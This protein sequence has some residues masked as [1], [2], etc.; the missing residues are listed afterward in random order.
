MS[1]SYQ[2]LQSFQPDLATLAEQAEQLL[3]TNPRSLLINGRLFAEQLATLVAR[4]EGIEPVY[5]I[6]QIERIQ[7]LER[8]GIINSDIR[9]SLEWLRMNGNSA[10][11]EAKEI[12]IDIAL[13]AHRQ[14]FELSAWFAETYGPHSLEIP[15]YEIPVKPA[16][17]VDTKNDSSTSEELNETLQKL[18]EDQLSGKLLTSID[19]KFREIQGMLDRFAGNIEEWAQKEKKS[20]VE[21]DK[22]TTIQEAAIEESAAGAEARG[23]NSQME[24]ADYLQTLSLQ[25]LDKRANGGALWIIGGWELKDKLFALKPFGFYFRFARN[26]SQSTKRKPAWF[27]MGKDP[28]VKRWVRI[29]SLVTPQS[30]LKNINQTSEGRNGKTV[31]WYKNGILQGQFPSI[32]AAATFI[33][34]EMNLKHMPF[35]PIMKSIHQNID[36][37]DLSFSF[38]EVKG[39]IEHIEEET[40]ARSRHAIS[41]SLDSDR[42][43]YD[44]LE[45]PYSVNE[46]AQQADFSRNGVV[47]P[48]AIRFKQLEDYR[49]S[50]L[51]EISE[52]LGV[53]CFQDWTEERLKEL[54]RKEP[55]LLHDVLVQLWFYGFEF[56]GEL[57]RFIKLDRTSD[58]GAIDNLKSG[59][60]L[61]NIFPLDISRSLERFGVRS[62]DQ[63][64]GIPLSSL[65]WLLRGRYDD[66]IQALEPYTLSE[67]GETVLEK[68]R[69]EQPLVLHFQGRALEIP[70]S[71][72]DT[73]I[74]SMPIYGCSALLS[75]LN[76]HCQ[77][78]LVRELPSDLSELIPLIP[79]VG[80]GSVNKMFTQ[81]SDYIN[82]IVH[83]DTKSDFN[84][85]AALIEKD[86]NKRA[87]ESG[88]II[89]QDVVIELDPE[90]CAMRLGI[91]HFPMVTKLMRGIAAQGWAQVG[92][93][94][95]RLDKLLV[96]DGVGRMAISKFI[97]QLKKRL[98]VFRLE[99]QQESEWITMPV[100]QRISLSIDNVVAAWSDKITEHNIANNRNLQMLHMRWTERREGRKATLESLGQHFGL[101]RERV[102]QII[103]KQLR[104]FHP[105]VVSFDNLLKSTCRQNGNYYYYYLDIHEKF[106]Y[107]LIEQVVEESEGL[108][109]LENYGWWTTKTE[110]EVEA[111]QEKVRL[112]IREQLRGNLV[113]ND[114]LEE[115]I[116]EQKFELPVKLA[117]QM[118]KEHLKAT[119]D[120]KYLLAASTKA[121]IVEMV[122]RQYPNGVEVYKR[123]SELKD[124]ANRIV[125]D[126]FVNER[127]FTSVCTRDE[128]SDAAYLW[129]RGTYIHSSFVNVKPEL[130]REVSELALQM[131]EKRSPI[132]VGRLFQMF[133]DRLVDANVPN[134]YALYSMLRKYGSDG[135]APNKF[136][137]IWHKDDAFQLSNAELIKAFMRERQEPQTLEALR[138]E[139]IRKRGWKKF[140]LE[141]SMST[142]SDFISVDLGVVGLREF[143]PYVE[144]DFA[145]ITRELKVLLSETG[146]IHVNRLFES[147]KPQCDYMGIRSSYLLYD[148]LQGLNL[149]DCK[150]VRYPLVASEDHPLEELSLQSI[151]E[152]YIAD[153]EAEVPRE[154]VYHWVTEEVGARETTLDNAL[155]NST[156]IYYYRSGQFG[157]YIHAS[158]FGWTSEKENLLTDY[159]VEQ[160]NRQ[161]ATA[162]YYVTVESLWSPERFPTLDNGVEWTE[163]LFIDCL[164]KSGKFNLLGSMN[165]IIVREDDRRIK[166]ETDWIAHVL[167]REF[168]GRTT[169]K[170]L[171]QTLQRLKYSKDGRFLFETT[172][173]LDNGTAPFVVVADEVYRK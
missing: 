96:L 10:V 71:L 35:T 99:K 54:Y 128:F 7:L 109:Y 48:D 56:R 4:T 122:L 152:Q 161:E 42:E 72:M 32:K 120:G 103:K 14:M 30:E 108:I 106:E 66:A 154:L 5:S 19:E 173:K 92:D 37:N 26:G 13:T 77:I 15:A 95:T 82:R 129:G 163:D 133:K 60:R 97:E 115:L 61:S 47:V 157:E 104:Q 75:R 74:D 142:D 137:H 41:V 141:F 40:A 45:E 39:E 55:K 145:S 166:D 58:G 112:F 69:M 36:W 148:L 146:V 131:L 18:I 16:Q 86:E 151:V 105:D 87:A 140:T 83:G 158:R 34:E 12:P 119:N 63:L 17:H 70:E 162:R 23:N 91:E 84:S 167:E 6:K 139:F 88:K 135:L 126:E 150:F 76:S 79:G 98:H 143:Y 27:L 101:T 130:I 116:S 164:R 132:S 170:E 124:E 113:T 134:E 149:S 68:D 117:M 11:H 169:L 9:S 90:D 123:A 155:A 1:S 144:E 49:P 168:N 85:K 21:S 111:E 114:Q 110:E 81:L 172:A 171:Q 25:I 156:N 52:Q 159:V 62:T 107:G 51:S 93:L 46:P 43:S 31:Y 22:S 8:R 73:E 67:N 147:V 24:I 28:S 57:S 29:D 89:W 160:L 50:R 136:P 64:N 102:R 100:E 121:D 33:K 59:L 65:E 2:I 118:A 38:K 125:P 165:H 78:A 3:W 80:P 20:D 53:A 127:E 153:Q 44:L 138:E 94:P